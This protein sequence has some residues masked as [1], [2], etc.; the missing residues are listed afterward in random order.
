[1]KCQSG[2]V[3]LLESATVSSRPFRRLPLIPVFL[4]SSDPE[5][6]TGSGETLNRALS[7]KKVLTAQ[8]ILNKYRLSER[9][10]RC[11]TQN[12]TRSFHPITQS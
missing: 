5:D 1:V 8:L 4:L 12:G 11:L 9:L 6:L 2:S 3:P 7:L 10:I